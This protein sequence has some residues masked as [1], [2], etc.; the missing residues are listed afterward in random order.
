MRRSLNRITGDV[1]LLVA[2]AR[3]LQ[4]EG[5]WMGRATLPRDL[6]RAVKRLEGKAGRSGGC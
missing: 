3:R 6:G 4:E 2:V 5:R 1:E